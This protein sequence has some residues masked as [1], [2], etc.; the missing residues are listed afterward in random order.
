MAHPYAARVEVLVL[1]PVEARLAGANVDLGTPKQRALVCALALSL[2]RPVA[3]DTI[4]DLLWGD[5][6]PPGVAG[7]LQSYVSGLRKVLEPTRERRRPAERL[8]TVAPGYALRLEPSATDAGRFV[9][10]VGEQHRLLAGSPLTGHTGMSRGALESA[11]ERLSEALDLWRGRPYAEL[12]DAPDAVAERARLDDLRLVALEDRAVAA[13]A[14]GHH[15]TVAAELEALTAAH[16]LRERMWGLRAVALARAGRQAEAL[17]ALSTVRTVLDDEL[18]LEP[19]IELREL[20]TAILRQDP[21]LA[22]AEPD[23]TVPAAPPPQVPVQRAGDG[24]GDADAG[25]GRPVPAQ[26]APLVGREAE[27]AALQQLVDQAADGTAACALLVGEPGIGKSRLA[28]EL[29][30]RA[31]ERGFATLLGRCSQDEGAPPFWP[32][33]T[34]LGGLGRE[35]PRV[36]AAAGDEG[37]RFRA[38]EEITGIVLEAARQQPVLL[39]MDDLHWADAS[40]LGALRVLVDTMTDH[41]LLVVGTRRTHPEPEGAL[42][43]LGETAAR[44]HA[45]RLD[46]TG[47]GVR[48]AA[49]VA[50]Q[51]IGS[52]PSERESADL[53]ARTEGNPFFI[54]EYARLAGPRGHLRAL[55]DEPDPPVAVQDVLNRRIS[56]LPGDTVAALRVAAVIGRRFE[57]PTLARATGIDED[58]L[59]DVVEPAQAVGLLREDGIDRY[60]FGHALVVDTLLSG[61]RPSRLARVHARVAEALPAGPGHEAELARHWLAAG[62]AYAA[63]AWRAAVAAAAQ[64]SALH[65]HE[66]AERLLSAAL[67][68]LEHDEAATLRDRYDVVMAL[69]DAHRWL[70]RWS[71][72]VA[73]VEQ[74]I[75]LAHRVDDVELVARA[76]IAPNQGSLWHSAPH[77]EVHEG[78][79]AALRESLAR[80]PDGDGALRCRVQ[81]SLAHELGHLASLDER[82]ALVAEAVAMAERIGD[83]QLLVEARMGTWMPT[84]ARSTTVERFEQVTAALEL[85]RE[86]GDDRAALV[87]SCLRCVALNDLGRPALM[88]EEI[89]AARAEAVRLRIPFGLIVL[90]GL[91]L[92]WRALAGRFDECAEIVDR[93]ASLSEPMSLDHV[94]DALASAQLSLLRWQG[95]DAELVAM[96]EPVVAELPDFAVV[97]AAARW[98]SGDRDGA[99][100]DVAAHPPDLEHEDIYSAYGWIHAAELALY[101][102]DRDLGAAVA[103]RLAP[104]AGESVGAGSMIASGPVDLYL[105]LAACACGETDDAG[106][107]ADRAAELCKAWEIPVVGDWLERL[108]AEYAF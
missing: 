37:V 42:A 8:V 20:Q 102:G 58:D 11:V 107:H 1:G 95:R 12:E 87:T 32:W 48:D 100:A 31:R 104:Y 97:L 46:L 45:L 56:R 43:D 26:V 72:L 82:R 7:T 105:A 106:G 5:E 79:L 66:G 69:I 21:V 88:L 84:W 50:E 61:V 27:L 83:P 25:V 22:W 10:M 76:A 17:D 99:R 44:R 54:V 93:I 53:Q 86:I 81:L 74:A 14:L 52:R 19:G 98:R 40:S 91:L 28:A 70:A 41:R 80:L 85:A 51:V 9:A 2:G 55:L 38:W 13:L 62:P 90:D 33:T 24:D 57:A 36:E 68:R 23:A 103:A 92:S 3:V 16:P 6:A 75:E 18:G 59:L 39:V 60:V 94:G 63:Q 35:L 30:R 77:G 47:L 101:L 108:R 65:D 15:A 71:D 67:D 49:A 73:G 64:S 29:G 96:L 34:V 4:I 78:V 89:E